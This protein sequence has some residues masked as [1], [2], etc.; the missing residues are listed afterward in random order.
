[1]KKYAVGFIL[2][3]LIAAAVYYKVNKPENPVQYKTEKLSLGT[4]Q[5]TVSATGSV[6]AVVTVLVGTQVSGTIKEIFADFNSQVKK[7]ET[8]ARIDP[9]MFTAQADQAR[10]NLLAARANLKKSEA[11]LLDAQRTFKRNSELYAK[12]FIAKSEVETAETAKDT[13]LAQVNVSKAQ[14]AQSEAALNYAEANLRYTRILSPVDGIVVS[15]N[16]DVGQTVAASFQTPTLFNI[17]Q[18]LT[19]MQINANVDEADIGK[20]KTGQKVEFTVDAYPDVTFEGE[21]SQIRNAPINVQNVIT[22]DVIIKV[23]N[24]DLKLKP[25]MTANVSIIIT[26]KENVLRV[27]N[28]ALRFTPGEKAQD[29]ERLKG[30]GLWVMDQGRPKRIKITPGIGDG[31]FTEIISDTLKEGDSVIVES[32]NKAKGAPSAFR[33][34]RFF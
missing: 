31:S 21:V 34:P 20:I 18:D 9:T 24:P 16:V 6:N 28:T 8:I 19:R 3:C 11:T 22:Y 10:A 33:G 14:V 12:D 15:R 2:L 5:Q 29:G 1:M 13:A 32:L 25:G 17:A 27:S 23:D 4:I 26:I 30:Y 7:G